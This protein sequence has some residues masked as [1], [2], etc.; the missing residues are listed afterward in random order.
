VSAQRWQ[1]FL[2][3]SPRSPCN[4]RCQ[5]AGSSEDIDRRQ[6]TRDCDRRQRACGRPAA[7]RTVRPRQGP[8]RPC[9][10]SP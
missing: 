1:P 9:N 7:R 2:R 3:A 6:T 8:Q 4:T 10:R 5:S